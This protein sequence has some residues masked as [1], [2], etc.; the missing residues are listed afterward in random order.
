M[1]AG[2][3]KNVEQGLDSDSRRMEKV[4]EMNE[5]ALNL[6]ELGL[7]LGMRRWGP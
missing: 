2:Y 4:E 1:G 6:E 5:L 7:E 3:G